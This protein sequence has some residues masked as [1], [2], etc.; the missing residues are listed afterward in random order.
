MNHSFLP[1][2][3]LFWHIHSPH[4]FLT[5]T[6][7]LSLSQCLLCPHSLLIALTYSPYSVFFFAF[8][9]IKVTLGLG[10]KSQIVLQCLSWNPAVEAPQ[11]QSSLGISCLLAQWYAFLPGWG[12]SGVRWWMTLR[13]ERKMALGYS[14]FPGPDFL[15]SSP[16]LPS[17]MTL[18]RLPSTH[19]PGIWC[20]LHRARYCRGSKVE[21]GGVP[22]NPDSSRAL[23]PQE[24]RS[25][26][27]A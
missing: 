11:G 9:F 4:S 15:G 20:S 17:H 12:F 18:G 26:R 27:Q 8:C 2:K 22:D 6:K 10:F 24:G 21:G 19:A 14:Q 13:S 1:P 23:R 3:D 7:F 16:D 5:W 25:K